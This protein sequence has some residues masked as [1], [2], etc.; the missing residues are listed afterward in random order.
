[1]AGAAVLNEEGVVILRKPGATSIPT[2]IDHLLKDR[3]SWEEHYLPR[4]QY[5]EERVTIRWVNVGGGEV[6]VR[7][8]TAGMN[9]CSKGEWDY[10]YGLQCGSL[11][12]VIRNWWGLVGFSYLQMDDPTSSTR[13]SIRSA[14]SATA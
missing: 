9:T 3:A 2:E 5:A 6:M 11:Y 4:L 10:P 7:S 13:S 8:P 12:G 1:M 14:S